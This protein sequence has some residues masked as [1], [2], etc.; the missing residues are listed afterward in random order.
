MP[1]FLTGG[2]SLGAPR[3]RADPVGDERRFRAALDRHTHAPEIAVDQDAA[4]AHGFAFESPTTFVNGRRIGASA[5]ASQIE[6][7]VR[8]ALGP[9]GSARGAAG[10]P[11]RR[12][13][14]RTN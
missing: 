5:P 12:P 9:A 7:A 10:A 2:T 14:P 1:S 4:R 13:T 3:E 6:Q 8:T 11:A